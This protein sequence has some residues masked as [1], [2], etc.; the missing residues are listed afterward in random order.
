M[1]IFAN[2]TQIYYNNSVCYGSAYFYKQS[3]IECFTEPEECCDQIVGKNL[4]YN[5]CVNGTINHCSIPNVAEED[6]GYILQLFGILFLTVTGTVIIYGF[7][8]F[9]CYREVETFD[10]D[11][12]RQKLINERS[13]QG[14]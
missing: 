9:V 7:C 14:L 2:L 11:V 3:E 1:G 10:R 5:K 4:I 8:R 12:E 6:L 13:Y